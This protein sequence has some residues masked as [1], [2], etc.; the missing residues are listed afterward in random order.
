MHISVPTEDQVLK[1]GPNLPGDMNGSGVTDFEDMP[2]FVLALLRA[3]DA[4][5]PIITADMNG[6]GCANGDDIQPFVSV[7]AG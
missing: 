6:D 4:P 5:L 2:G 7:I 1:V 3:S